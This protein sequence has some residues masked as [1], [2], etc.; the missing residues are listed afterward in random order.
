MEHKSCKVFLHDL[1]GTEHSVDVTAS[2][3]Y[4]AVALA[5]KILKRTEWVEGISQGLGDIKVEVQTV[6]VQHHVELMDFSKW[7]KQRGNKP[8]DIIRRQKVREIL[9]IPEPVK[10]EY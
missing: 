2:T 4:E 7:L 9:G 6:P 10:F 3:L 1:K 5:L 8:V